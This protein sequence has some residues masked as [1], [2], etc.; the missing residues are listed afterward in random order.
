MELKHSKKIKRLYD[1]VKTSHFDDFFF[2]GASSNNLCGCG[3]VLSLNTDHYF[4]L[5]LGGGIDTNKKN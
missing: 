5:R 4:S 2:D 1:P 3:M